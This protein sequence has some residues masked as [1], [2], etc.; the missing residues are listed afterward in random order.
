MN[1]YRRFLAILRNRGEE[2]VL[3][4]IVIRSIGILIGV[5][6][7]LASRNI[8]EIKVRA[9][10]GQTD[11]WAWVNM[12]YV[13]LFTI[14]FFAL[15]YIAV[16]EIVGLCHIAHSYGE[17]EKP[18][19]VGALRF[20]SK[21]ALNLLQGYGVT[22][23]FVIFLGAILFP[24]LGISPS[25]FKAFAMPISLIEESTQIAVH[26]AVTVVALIALFYIGFRFIFTFHLFSSHPY[27]LLKSAKESWRITRRHRKLHEV[28]T[29]GMIL[30]ALLCIGL[31][32]ATAVLLFV[33]I[34]LVN[35][36]FGLTFSVLPA[37]LSIMLYASWI[38]IL[39]ALISVMIA[40]FVISTLSAYLEIRMPKV[41]GH[42][43]SK[44]L[45]HIAERESG[46]KILHRK[47]TIFIVGLIAFMVFAYIAR[48]YIYIFRGFNQTPTV[49]A[50]RGEGLPENSVEAMRR[51]LENG[52]EGIETDLQMLRDGT[53]IVYHDETLKRLYKVDARIQDSSLAELKAKRV[54][55]ATLDELILLIKEYKQK[56]ICDWLLEI[57]AYGGYDQTL[58]I[59]KQVYGQLDKEGLLDCAYIGSFDFQVMRELENLHPEIQTNMYLLGKPFQDEELKAFDAV[60]V[61]QSII[62]KNFVRKL[63]HDDKKV[64]VWTVNDTK[65]VEGLAALG[66]SGIITDETRA[67]KAAV[68]EYGSLFNGQSD[69]RVVSI[70]G[71]T[72]LV[73]PS[74]LWQFKLR[75]SLF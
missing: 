69:E 54:S 24:F 32:I 75:Y 14:S 5:F 65:I 3:Y 48:S 6:V 70:F 27:S 36:F 68:N 64:F 8:I 58:A 61:E 13:I 47:K 57:K 1:V 35:S 71:R 11:I 15:V 19:L 20:A 49:I 72:F 44:S 7:A 66:V 29:W 41:M 73:N 22:I 31:F 37:T 17:G 62:T 40:P 51:A 34:G 38:Y 59:G 67:L 74:T 16:I 9:L 63:Q 10:A 55:V 33:I 42:D 52:A 23:L 53:I 56:D 26:Q 4:E 2:L 28:F 30:P 25:L 12:P 39:T 21:K 50:H 43:S 46:W 60:S 18:T 45:E